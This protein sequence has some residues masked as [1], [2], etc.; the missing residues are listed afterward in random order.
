MKIRLI[1]ISLIF[2]CGLSGSDKDCNTLGVFRPGSGKPLI[3]VQYW[4]EVVGKVIDIIKCRFIQAVPPVKDKQ[5]AHVIMQNG[6]QARVITYWFSKD[7]DRYNISYEKNQSY[8][9][10]HLPWESCS[11]LVVIPDRLNSKFLGTCASVINYAYSQGIATAIHCPKIVDENNRVV[12]SD[13]KEIINTLV[14]DKKVHFFNGMYGFEDDGII[15]QY[16]L[17]DFLFAVGAALFMFVGGA[18]VMFFFIMG[19]FRYNK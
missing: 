13:K 3:T 11:H 19:K 14:G 9:L 16:K 2:V 12:D 7:D 4:D 18:T 8:D 5:R 1:L 6:D 17:N 15:P 10:S